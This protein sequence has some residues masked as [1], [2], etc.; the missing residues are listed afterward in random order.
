MRIKMDYENY[1]KELTELEEW[2][3][4]NKCEVTVKN[5]MA[6]I[7][8]FPKA[9]LNELMELNEDMVNHPNHYNQ[10]T[11]EAIDIIEECIAGAPD[12]IT[13]MLHAKALKYLLRL[14]YKENP[15]QDAKKAVWYLQRL[16]KKINS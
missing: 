16:I 1:I 5:G 15:A 9:S 3:Q 14:W 4:E 10:G 8:C 6:Q 7:D 11:Q 2:D 13:G 12:P